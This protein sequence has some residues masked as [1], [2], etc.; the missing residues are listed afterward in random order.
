MDEYL[1]ALPFYQGSQAFTHAPAHIAQDLQTVRS[2]NEKGY[3]VVAEDADSF[4]KPI[5]G[6]KLEAVKIKALELFF[7]EHSKSPPWAVAKSN[8]WAARTAR[9]NYIL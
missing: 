6:R 1:P 4:G 5:K 3:A 7:R 2:G 9:P 8:S